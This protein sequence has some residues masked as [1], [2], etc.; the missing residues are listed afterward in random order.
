MSMF[1]A[2]QMLRGVL[3]SFASLICMCVVV[4]LQQHSHAHIFC[5]GVVSVYTKFGEE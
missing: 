3:K 5:E 4:T 2:V 1:L